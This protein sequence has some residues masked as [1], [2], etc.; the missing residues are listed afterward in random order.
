MSIDYDDNDDDDDEDDV[1][2]R[3]HLTEQEASLKRAS[4]AKTLA[5]FIHTSS[6]RTLLKDFRSAYASK[7]RRSWAFSGQ[8][9]EET[10]EEEEAEEEVE[11][12]AEEEDEEEEEEEEE[13]EEE[14]KKQESGRNKG[15]PAGTPRRRPNDKAGKQPS[16]G[17]IDISR[18]WTLGKD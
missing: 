15:R 10:R 13:K 2:Q 6:W 4:M 9:V 17:T 12:E 11:G 5:H 8:D 14:E 3:E 1:L 7:R 16:K 18:A